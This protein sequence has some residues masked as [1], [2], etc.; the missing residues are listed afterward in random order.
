[1]IELDG[2]RRTYRAKGRS[3]VAVDGVSLSVRAGEVFGVVGR[4]GAGKSTLLR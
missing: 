1:M 3:V 4:S 2:L